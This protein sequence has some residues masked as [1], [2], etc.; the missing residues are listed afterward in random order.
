MNHDPR[1]LPR[2]AGLGLL[3]VGLHLALLLWLGWRP[4]LPLPPVPAMLSVRLAPVA[5][6]A[7][8]RAA[9]PPPP[10]PSPLGTRKPAPA[11]PVPPT[12][13]APELAS[14]ANASTTQ[15]GA[16]LDT[17]EQM[18]GRYATRLPPPVVLD[19]EVRVG[20][21]LTPSSLPSR[22]VWQTSSQHYSLQFENMP[23]PMGGT[24]LRYT[25]EGGMNDGGIAPDMALREQDGTPT[26]RTSFDRDAG[27][28]D[29]G[30][31]AS[32]RL[33][34]ATQD[35]ASLLMQLAG[36]GLARPEQMQDVVEFDVAASGGRSIVRFAV[37]GPEQLDTPL[38]VL[39]VMHLTQ[40]VKT[41]EILLEIWL[42]PAMNWYPVQLRTSGPAGVIALQT[43]R[44]ATPGG[45]AQP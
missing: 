44:S 12:V 17:G 40:Q 33:N 15:A 21:A 20:P 35:T 34:Q 37:T 31:G 2:L 30:T 9:P 43:L 4:Q 32:A 8:T 22:L 19:Y 28:V 11:K 23:D 25:S 3:S 27:R 24:P 16:D 38:G 5:A 18:P 26:L 7:A 41:G 10:A 1:F 45:A 42:A 6:P 13:T 14:T 29:F 36:M 39:S